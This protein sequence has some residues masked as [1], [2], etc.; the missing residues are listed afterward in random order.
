MALFVWTWDSGRM[1]VLDGVANSGLSGLA[2][3]ALLSLGETKAGYPYLAPPTWGEG[4][5][6]WAGGGAAAVLLS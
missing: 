6:S 4:N 1:G 2:L 3:Q 5:L